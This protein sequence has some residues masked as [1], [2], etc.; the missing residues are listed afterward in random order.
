MGLGTVSPD[1]ATLLREVV[2][3][4]L[5]LVVTGGTGAGKTTVLAALVGGVPG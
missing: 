2:A 1:M 5:S 4:R 3:A